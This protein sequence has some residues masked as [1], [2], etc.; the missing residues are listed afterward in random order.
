M[1]PMR[2][3][4]HRAARCTFM[5]KQRAKTSGINEAIIAISDRIVMGKRPPAVDL[6]MR[7]HNGCMILGHRLCG[8]R[9]RRH[10]N[11]NI[12]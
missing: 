12:T 6:C 11:L 5:K 10:R 1:A 4:I 3:A 7:N 9:A 8:R 2:M